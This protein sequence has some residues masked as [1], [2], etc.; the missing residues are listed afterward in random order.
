MN[1]EFWDYIWIAFGFIS[2]AGLAWAS[3]HDE[4][5]HLNDNSLDFREE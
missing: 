2:I 4:Y 1:F 3:V 5:S